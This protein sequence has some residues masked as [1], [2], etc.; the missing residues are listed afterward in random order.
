MMPNEVDAMLR[1]YKTCMA[2]G[3]HLRIEI[4]KMENL[5]LKEIKNAIGEEALHAQQYSGMPHGSDMGSPVE[6]LVFK[7]LGGYTPPMVHVMQDELA[8]MRREQTQCEKCV[9]YVDGWMQA[10]NEREQE[11]VRLQV[12]D[13]MYWGEILYRFAHQHSGIFSK[14]SL[15]R[16]KAKALEKI[17]RVAG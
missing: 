13:G 14:S 2:R 5:I 10:L 12:I 17:Y 3:T 16:I 1:E 7:Y 8:R 15:R 6:D 11:V 4:E 9:Q